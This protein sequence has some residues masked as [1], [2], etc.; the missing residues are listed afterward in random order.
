MTIL[1]R[2]LKPYAGI[3]DNRTRLEQY[4][5]V[6]LDQVAVVPWTRQQKWL[7]FL[8][9]TKERIS[10]ISGSGNHH[11]ESFTGCAICSSNSVL[12]LKL[13]CLLIRL[14]YSGNFSVVH[15]RQS[16]IAG[17]RVQ[18]FLSVNFFIYSFDQMHSNDTIIRRFV[19][20]QAFFAV[21]GIEGV[22]LV[23]AGRIKDFIHT[24]RG[25]RRLEACISLVWQLITHKGLSSLGLKAESRK[26]R[27]TRE[28]GY[29]DCR[30][31]AIS[32]ALCPPPTT[33]KRYLAFSYLNCR[34]TV[35]KY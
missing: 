5:I 10:P 33:A 18:Q 13:Y 2:S 4:A 21:R 8:Q 29:L 30:S 24:V 28:L 11:I 6:P 35:F 32:T 27:A 16:P 23:D 1:A 17:I 15:Q 14:L 26:I 12:Q 34:G 9:D 3:T 20:D 31:S 25:I 19:F 7:Q 22:E